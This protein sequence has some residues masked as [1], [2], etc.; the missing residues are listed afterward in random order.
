MTYKDQLKA[1]ITKMF[2]A[3]D[4]DSTMDA[5][6]E[7]ERIAKNKSLSKNDKLSFNRNFYGYLR[8]VESTF[9]EDLIKSTSKGIA[10]LSA[11]TADQREQMDIL[12]DEYKFSFK[13]L[14]GDE[15]YQSA[16]NPETGK[17]RLPFQFLFFIKVVAINGY[18]TIKTTTIP[19]SILVKAS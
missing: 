4:Y 13:L 8:E 9:E 5:I 1:Q 6:E 16:W 10:Y 12:G 17:C 19:S 7:L 14:D 15:Q 3:E 18:D 11:L 2:T